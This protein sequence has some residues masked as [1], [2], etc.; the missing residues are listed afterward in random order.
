M[1]AGNAGIVGAYVGALVTLC[2]GD[3]DSGSAEAGCRSPALIAKAAR[4]QRCNDVIFV[5]VGLRSRIFTR[6]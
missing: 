3:S 2:V 4:M 5:P 6:L 1:E